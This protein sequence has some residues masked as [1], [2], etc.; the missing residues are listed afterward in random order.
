MLCCVIF[1]LVRFIP[2]CRCQ[3]ANNNTYHVKGR[4]VGTHKQNQSLYAKFFKELTRVVKV[5][6]RV[7]LMTIERKILTQVIQTQSRHGWTLVSETYVD[8]GY[9]ATLFELLR[10]VPLPN[11]LPATTGSESNAREAVAEKAVEKAVEQAVEKAAEQ[12]EKV[13]EQ[14]IEPKANDNPSNEKNSTPDRQNE[15]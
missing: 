14:A 12:A 10:T 7:L 3:Q 1:L 6:G 2:Y 15:K 9:K 11:P 4:R 8:N 13:A 5:G